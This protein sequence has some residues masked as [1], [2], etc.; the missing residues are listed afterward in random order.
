MFY[1]CKS[2]TTAPYLPAE[3]LKDGCYGAMFAGC[4]KL[5]EIKCNAVTTAMDATFVWVSGVARE[6][7]F[8]HNVNAT[9]WSD[10]GGESDIPEGWV[11]LAITD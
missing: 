5:S 4:S 2:L 9:C 7:V 8:Y 11:R 6:G 10:D 1:N 3:T